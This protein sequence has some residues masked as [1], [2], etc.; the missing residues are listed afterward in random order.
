MG[1]ADRHNS[2]GT[3]RRFWRPAFRVFPFVLAFALPERL[4]AQETDPE[5]LVKRLGD[6]SLQV[7]D[8]AEQKLREIGPG[9]LEAV[10][11]GERSDDPE[12]AERCRRL[13]EE[14]EWQDKFQREAAAQRDR[15]LGLVSFEAK[16]WGTEEILG[17]ITA[18]TGIGFPGAKD[19]AGR[20]PSLPLEGRKHVLEVLDELCRRGNYSTPDIGPD[21]PRKVFFSRIGDPPTAGWRY[22][23]G[24]AVDVSLDAPA[25]GK[26][27]QMVVVRLRE[28]LDGIVDLEVRDVLDG[29]RQPLPVQRCSYHSVLHTV[30]QCPDFE[31]RPRWELCH[32]PIQ[33]LVPEGEPRWVVLKGVRHWLVAMEHE[34]REP[35]KGDRCRL[36]PAEIEI[37]PTQVRMTI[38]Q[39][40]R[41]RLGVGFLRTGDV[42]FR[43]KAGEELPGG[44][45]IGS[46]T[47]GEWVRYYK[48]GAW[49]G[50]RTAPR[51]EALDPE[52]KLS[53]WT[54]PISNV[55]PG[56]RLEQIAAIRVTVHLPVEEPFEMTLPIP[57]R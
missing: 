4:R 18:E 21:F 54:R 56:P 15:R 5:T 1:A 31:S 43:L 23:E 52:P 6:E 34:F 8:M 27:G 39:P 51:V 50:C 24:G 36:G 19:I 37:D 25:A 13:R 53:S 28:V 55:V 30:G 14:L 44:F 11:R 12:V 16:E 26:G 57:K 10:R 49:C 7:R 46:V 47:G 32:H 29:D 17:R 9:A 42:T 3:S 35:K 38:E 40:V 41:E 2:V 48:G 33:V 20:V 22:F 45:P